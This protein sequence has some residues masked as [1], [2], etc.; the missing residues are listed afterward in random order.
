[1][2]LSISGKKIDPVKIAE[3]FCEFSFETKIISTYNTVKDSKTGKMRLEP[4]CKIEIFDHK[5]DK[6][7]WTSLW[8]KLKNIFEL[9]CAFITVPNEYR[10][11]ILNWPGIFRPTNCP[12]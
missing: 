4:G 7:L 5:K 12:G 6:E 3:I 8:D 1:M 2:Q 9:K 10:G 11:C